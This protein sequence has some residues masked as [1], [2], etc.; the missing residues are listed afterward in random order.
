MVFFEL[1]IIQVYVAAEESDVRYQIIGNNQLVG[2][3]WLPNTEKLSPAVLL[4]GGSG[5]GYENQ[6]AEWLSLSGFVVLNVR[7]FGAKDLP[8]Y[9][10]DVA[11]EYFNT[12]VS[13]LDN[14]NLVK[15]GAIRICACFLI[16][17]K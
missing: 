12:A 8:G 17:N 2:R 7:Y 10:V 4:I 13:W 6:D 5:G 1:L 15:K 16:A 14:H 3:L 11:I 9:L